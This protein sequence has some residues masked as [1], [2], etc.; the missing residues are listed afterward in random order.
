ME[1]QPIS[2]GVKSPGREANISPQSIAQVMNAS[3]YIVTTLSTLI[4]LSHYLS[5]AGNTLYSRVDE[6]PYTA[7][8]F[9]SFIFQ[10]HA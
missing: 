5:T 6:Q 4:I 1:C 9:I 10:T 8:G 3:C 2:F 7:N